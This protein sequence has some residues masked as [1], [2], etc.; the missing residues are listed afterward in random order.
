MAASSRLRAVDSAVSV[1]IPTYQRRDLVLAAVQSLLLQTI[2]PLEII[3]VI[4]GSTDG[5]ADALRTVTSRVPIIVIE[6]KNAG[7]AAARNAGAQIAKGTVLLFLDD[8][9]EADSAMIAEH[10]ASHHAGADAVLGHMPLHP[11]CNT[12]LIAS[13]VAEWARERLERLSLPGANLNLH[14]LLTG[15]LS[16]AAPVFQRTQGFDRRFTHNGAFGNEDVD[17]G[18][19]L[20]RSGHDIRFNPA[21]ISAQRYSVTPAQHLRQWRQAGQADVLFA[22]KHPQDGLEIL[23]L[24]GLK[25]RFARLVAR[26]LAR[27]AGW[28]LLM[29]PVTVAALKAGER[30]DRI[31]RKLFFTARTLH[32]W[33]GVEEAG[34]APVCKRLRV[35]AY[36]DISEHIGEGVLRDYSIPAPMFADQLGWLMKAGYQ[37]ITPAEF[38]AFSAG[39]GGLPRQAILVTFDDCYKGMVQAQEVL[40]AQG[41]SGLAFAVSRRLGKSNDWDAGYGGAP[42]KLMNSAELRGLQAGGV[43]IGGH[44]RNH[45]HLPDLAAD[46]IEAEV[47]GCLDDLE[48]EGLPRPRFLAYPYGGVDALVRDVTS[49]TGLAAAFTVTPG[50]MSAATDRMAIPR[51]EILR[52]DTRSRLLR[53]VRYAPL[54]GLSARIWRAMPALIRRS[55]EIFRRRFSIFTR[56]GAP[57]GSS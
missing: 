3:V 32:Y 28:S 13:G 35:L 52:R 30:T 15:Q 46:E 45:L 31:S 39:Q 11:D 25:S 37:A 41:L 10:L 8:D 44:S 9:M 49:R 24:N 40:A 56:T 16:V 1:I 54:I 5:S 29:R 47:A 12:N 51:I 34:G 43:E 4:D 26:P 50:V 6:Q 53:K 36:H 2:A 17:F 55:P 18:I 7:A 14:D 57:S 38:A 22:R 42:L 27:F 23:V 21:A 20:L 33:R 48:A 19:R